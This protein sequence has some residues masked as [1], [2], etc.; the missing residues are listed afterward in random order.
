MPSMDYALRAAP[1]A[2]VP[3]EVRN[4]PIAKRPSGRFSWRCVIRVS[5]SVGLPLGDACRATILDSATQKMHFSP[6]LGRCSPVD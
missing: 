1:V 5:L 4:R 2:F 3:R 6:P